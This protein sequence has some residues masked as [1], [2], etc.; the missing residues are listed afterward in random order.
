MKTTKRLTY[1][2]ICG[3][4]RAIWFELDKNNIQQS[5]KQFLTWAKELGCTWPDDS[6]I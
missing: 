1:K 2:D 5:N 6:E 4:E 3:D